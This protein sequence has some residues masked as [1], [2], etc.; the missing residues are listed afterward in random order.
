MPIIHLLSTSIKHFCFFSFAVAAVVVG[1]GVGVV[2]VV[3]AAVAVAFV[4]VAVA[5]AAVV[6]VVECN[7]RLVNA[8]SHLKNE[9]MKIQISDCL[10]SI[11]KV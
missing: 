1:G 3:V 6:V 2:V 10:I 11:F 7:Q 5:V 9:D 4:V 8:L